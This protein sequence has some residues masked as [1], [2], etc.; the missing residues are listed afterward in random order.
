[1]TTDYLPARWVLLAS[2]GLACLL[3]GVAVWLA[4][5]WAAAHLMVPVR[6]GI[7]VTP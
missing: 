7:G 5:A 1:M 4:P 2:A 3:T 6:L